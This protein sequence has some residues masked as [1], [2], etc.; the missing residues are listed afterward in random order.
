M[1]AQSFHQTLCSFAEARSAQSKTMTKGPSNV[2]DA[3]RN[4]REWANQNVIIDSAVN[5]S[6]AAD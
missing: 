4:T 1:N 2:Q 3:R 5:D 6:T